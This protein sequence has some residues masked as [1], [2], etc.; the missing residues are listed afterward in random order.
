LLPGT[1]LEKEEEGYGGPGLQAIMASLKGEAAHPLKWLCLSKAA[2]TSQA[3]ASLADAFSSQSLPNLTRL[4]LKNNLGIGN[5]AMKSLFTGLLRH[6][7]DLEE[8]DVLNTGMGK[9]AAEE[10][11]KVLKK[12]PWPHLRNLSIGGKEVTDAFVSG[13]ARSFSQGVEKGLRSLELEASAKKG[14][15]QLSGG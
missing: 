9:Q 10:F 2:M 11:I 1:N 12:N 13:L 5:D 7:E 15:Q 14:F 8:L 4:H 6:C 3:A